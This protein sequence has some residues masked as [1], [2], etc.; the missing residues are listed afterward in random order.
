VTI[1]PNLL[2]DLEWR[3]LLAH[4]TDRDAL[5]DALSGGSVRF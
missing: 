4:T 2:D 1:D 5:R 3:G